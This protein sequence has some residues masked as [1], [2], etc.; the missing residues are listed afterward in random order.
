VENGSQKPKGA[1]PLK[2]IVNVAEFTEE[3]KKKHKKLGKASDLGVK[4]V[5][6]KKYFVEKAY[7]PPT[8]EIKD[9]DDEP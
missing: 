3:D 8:E 2:K 5:F 9:S 4:I 7:A 1:I 6:K